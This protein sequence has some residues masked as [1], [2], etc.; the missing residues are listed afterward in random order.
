[1]FTTRS[2]WIRFAIVFAI[3]AL[4][5][6]LISYSINPGVGEGS[7]YAETSFRYRF[8][9]W[10]E[11]H[12]MPQWVIFL[13]DWPLFFVE[14]VGPKRNFDLPGCAVGWLISSACWAALWHWISVRMSHRE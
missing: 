14:I 10:L 4:L 6:L 5:F 1:M 9:V 7:E 3:C 11:F 12:D 13:T 8:G 2:Y